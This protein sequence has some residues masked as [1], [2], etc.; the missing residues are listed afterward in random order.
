MGLKVFGSLQWNDA[1]S[2]HLSSVSCHAVGH[3]IASSR[4]QECLGPVWSR[5]L[6]KQNWK[7]Q[8]FRAPASVLAAFLRK[9]FLIGSA[10]RPISYST[11]FDTSLRVWFFF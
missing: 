9:D 2:V 11:T 1:Q 4:P 8:S 7:C 3:G 10:G 5:A 6:T